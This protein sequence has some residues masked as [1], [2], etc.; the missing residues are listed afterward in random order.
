MQSNYDIDT[1]SDGIGD[2]DSTY[3]TYVVDPNPI[4]GASVNPEDLFIFVRLRAFPQSRSII[5]SDNVYSSNTQD[6][7]SFITANFQH[8]KGYAT[9]DY[10]NIGGAETNIEGLGIRNINIEVGASYVPKVQIEFVDVRGAAIFNN[11]E[12][13]GADGIN[14]NNS[15]FNSFFKLPYPIFELT[16]KG[17]YGKAVTYYLNLTS[18]NAAVDTSSGDFIIRCSFIGFDFAFLSDIMTKYVI[19]LNST[20]IGQKYLD[21]YVKKS[22]EVGLLSISQLIQ[23][24]TEISKLTEE[25]KTSDEDYLILK[26]YNALV[27][28]LLTLQT[29]I[30][31][32]VSETPHSLQSELG[33]L[34]SY[35]QLKN[36]RGHIF[37]RD[38]GVF[39]DASN[40][41][42]LSLE[43]YL[44][45]AINEVNSLIT[46]YEAQFPE[47][48][49]YKLSPFILKKSATFNFVDGVFLDS[50]KSEIL[51][52]EP[53]FYVDSFNL[54][55]LTGN[56]GVTPTTN[57]DI[58]YASFYGI[59]KQI[60]EVYTKIRQN[61]NSKDDKVISELNEKFSKEIGFN[62][63]IFNVFE[64]I[65]GNVDIF[66]TMLYEV[67]R[68][69][70]SF[71]KQRVG[72]LQNYL[73]KDNNAGSGFTDIAN[74][75]EVIYPF[76]AVYDLAGNQ[77]WIGDVVGEN[78]KYYPEINLVNTLVNGVLGVTSTPTVTTTISGVDN[79]YRWPA[80]NPIDIISN[81]YANIE[82]F[83]YNNGIPSELYKLIIDRVSTQLNET[84]FIT[85]KIKKFA[86]IDSTYFVDIISNS[87]IKD[88]LASY[89]E[90]KFVSEGLTYYESSSIE[91][92]LESYDFNVD[93]TIFNYFDNKFD[94]KFDKYVKKSISPS[95]SKYLQSKTKTLS[96]I[97]KISIDTSKYYITDFNIIYGDYT[98]NYSDEN[99]NNL[100]R[101]D[102]SNSNIVLD[103][104]RPAITNIHN[105]KFIDGCK[106][107]F[108]N[109][110]SYTTYYNDI[111]HNNIGRPLENVLL[112]NT[113]FDTFYY[114]DNTKEMKAY[115]LL[116]TIPYK[117]SS[118]LFDYISQY[119]G[120]YYIPHL[121]IIKVGAE[122]YRKINST[123]NNDILFGSIKLNPSFYLIEFQKRFYGNPNLSL[124]SNETKDFFVNEYL[125]FVN[126]TDFD[127]LENTIKDYIT[128][129]LNEYYSKTKSAEYQYSLN[130][131]G[132]LVYNFDAIV[133]T[134]P[135]RLFNKG[136][137]NIK[138]PDISGYL[139]IFYNN[140]VKYVQTNTNTI[141]PQNANQQLTQPLFDDKDTKIFIY[142]HLKNIYDKWLAY[143]KVDGKIYN[144]SSYVK[145]K[146]N[147]NKKLI[148]HFYF[149]DRT[150]SDIGDVA[151]LNPKS[152]L[153]TVNATDSNIYSFM[154]IV[155][156][157]NNFISFNLPTHINYYN[158]E[159]VVNM[160][161][162]YTFIEETSGG[163]SF[164][165][166]YV[167]G[168]SKILDLGNRVSYVNDGFDLK[169]NNYVNFPQ[170]LKVRKTPQWSKTPSNLTIDEEFKKE[171]LSKYNLGCFRVAYADQNQNIFTNIEVGQEEH[172]E[173]QESILVNAELASGRG[174]NKRIYKGMDLFNAYSVR[175]YQ[176]DVKCLGNMQIQPT[177]YFQLDNIPLFHGMHMIYNVKHNI[178]PH[179]IETS[180]VGR[181]ISKFSYPIVDKLTAF[182]NLSL[183]DKIEIG[184]PITERYE[185]SGNY[186]NP[187]DT[188]KGDTTYD[189]ILGDSNTS[190]KRRLQAQ[191]L[192]PLNGEAPDSNVLFQV[193][194]NTEVANFIV[195]SD[196][197]SDVLNQRLSKIFKLNPLEVPNYGLAAKRCATWVKYIFGDLGVV[198]VGN[199]ETH[200]WNWFMGLP[201]NNNWY[202]F[203]SNQKLTGWTESEVSQVVR[204]GSLLFG[205]Y[206][207]SKSKDES[208]SDMKEFTNHQN[209]IKILTDNKRITG[210][211]TFTPITH[212]GIFYNQLFY[213]HIGRV[214][215]SI[216]KKFVPVAAYYFLNDLKS[217]CAN[218]VV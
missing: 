195:N 140:L 83:N 218:N 177:Q 82:S 55:I 198:K 131:L 135:N 3:F 207:T 115:L 164:V 127:I 73:N 78:N 10:T 57:F 137:N 49:A 120:I 19:G 110:E 141:N 136:N 13:V 149:I 44:N 162:P 84:Q 37:I 88:I 33:S 197:T 58:I 52:Y 107:N 69:A 125:N 180:F 23:K 203:N 104:N 187:K 196:V 66:L 206:V 94:E 16:I 71:G 144:F 146:T 70:D 173:T 150:W 163:A 56:F 4:N 151:V 11:H 145:G 63:T 153:K 47:L 142:N 75:D 185:E 59:R 102:L 105:L 29:T 96:D 205:Y 171:Y 172:R 155:L 67:C 134:S 139:S 109:N 214:N 97:N 183:T 65:F 167:A 43:Q 174:A 202:Y 199:L 32:G 210:D 53:N 158:K 154:G 124:L 74:K 72:Y 35:N 217:I 212:I 116:Q 106:T 8:N 113:I 133:I 169:S 101:S 181:R 165:F 12:Q 213:E 216:S 118:E 201:E 50:I 54:Q 114:A 130:I 215:M 76:P 175:S 40:D 93:K 46:K 26:I 182:V 122:I 111:L 108:T 159:D 31:I 77:I 119:A 60:T 147:T 81:P 95:T 98:L 126:S 204:D 156:N 18:F 85:S 39:T 87:K 15:V 7:I 5:T 6:Q 138:Y 20:P 160:F 148:D 92:K 170:S 178:T 191:E 86:E 80:S 209:R 79:N 211:Y 112:K 188:T 200:A 48:S 89:G 17:Y 62:P 100:I 42:L 152:L 90:T 64:V 184:K 132:L 208:Y 143:S 25:Y 179:N 38:I 166:M 27:D 194:K 129:G 190:A 123:P 128:L 91:S 34:I 168:N 189:R 61:K 68:E 14:S 157:D 161:K 121:Q 99:I 117:D 45:D 51:K 193:I 9:T 36:D 1:I 2:K 103:Y 24:Y 21:D 30:G 22:G 28:K 176:T 41:V 192:T 186:I